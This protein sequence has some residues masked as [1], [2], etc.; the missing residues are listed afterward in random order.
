MASV[1]PALDLTHQGPKYQIWCFRPA[2]THYRVIEL[3]LPA[4]AAAQS[5]A[6]RPSNEPENVPPL[7][8]PQAT[9]M[10]M[11]PEVVAGVSF[12]PEIYDDA[13]GNY[14]PICGHCFWDNDNGA[15]LVCQ[16]LGFDNGSVEAT[17]DAYNV[18]AMP[19]GH[20]AE[21]DETLTEVH[22]R[23]KRPWGPELKR[24]V[25]YPRQSDRGTGGV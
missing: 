17:R 4:L 20:C 25:L 13:T 23:R 1:T 7:V 5:T 2:H 22:R 14:Y 16:E 24:R 15:S 10:L 11:R 9:G 6:E 12:V 3:V 8:R 21:R 19:V 18:D